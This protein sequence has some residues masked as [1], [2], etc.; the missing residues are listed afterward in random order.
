[1]SV[2]VITG[3][4]GLIGSEAVRWFVCRGF[5]VVGIDNDMRSSYFGAA[6]STLAARR[7]LEAECRGYRHHDLDIRD[8]IGIEKLFERYGGA[9]TAVLH[10]AAQ[11]SHE[12]AALDPET[13]FEVNAVATLGLLEAVRRHCPGAA[14]VFTS[15]NKVYGDMP[16]T[17]PLVELE[18]RW[19][20]PPTHPYHDGIDEQMSVDQSMHSLFGVS[21]TAADLCVQEYGRWFGMHT[22]VFRA[23]CV[24]GPWHV[25]V[26]LHG[27]LSYL[28]R[29]TATGVPYTIRGYK[30]KQVRDNIHSE[31]VAR[32]MW[33]FVNNPGS[34]RVYNIGGGRSSSCSVIEAID[35]CQAIAGRELQCAYTEEYRRGRPYVVD[36][37]H[38]PVSRRLSCVD[39]R[40]YPSSNARRDP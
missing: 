8:R 20:L 29:C 38:P 19:D 14:F 7:H 12:W 1:M 15:T 31:D 34:G 27:F 32:A 6:A 24:T 17:L 37:L 26:E 21:K 30:G 5:E 9:V 16:N 18:R 28:M 25:G 10:T 3:S 40:P 35:L 23:G 39:L 36:Q 22:A 33:A 13:D 4:A 2:A 11:P